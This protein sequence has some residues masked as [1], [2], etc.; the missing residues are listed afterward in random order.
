MVALVSAW[1]QRSVF[2]E[3]FR[4]FSASKIVAI[5][6]NCRNFFYREELFSCRVSKLTMW[7]ENNQLGW[8]DLSLSRLS[9][10]FIS[11]TTIHGSLN[12]YIDMYICIYIYI[13]A[14]PDIT[15]CII[16]RNVYETTK[17][18]HETGINPITFIDELWGMLE[19]GCLRRPGSNPGSHQRK[20]TWGPFH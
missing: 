16:T 7:H 15:R 10:F 5:F 18:K 6:I 13:F 3:C 4:V 8:I 1:Y 9:S 11:E 20:T 14:T 2:L 17:V 12:I 19:S